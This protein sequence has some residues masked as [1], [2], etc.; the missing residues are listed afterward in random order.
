MTTT[1]LHF[2]SSIFLFFKFET[3]SLNGTVNAIDS[4]TKHILNIFEK[5]NIFEIISFFFLLSFVSHS[6][7]RLCVSFVSMFIFQLCASVTAARHYYCHRISFYLL[8]SIL[9]LIH[10][11]IVVVVEW[12]KKKL[13]FVLSLCFLFFRKCNTSVI[14]VT[15][16]RINLYVLLTALQML[17]G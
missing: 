1:T 8:F 15:H 13:L 10:I 4:F 5:K 12:R 3:L 2:V 11:R 7:Q 14:V 6:P 16:P 17:N 9:F